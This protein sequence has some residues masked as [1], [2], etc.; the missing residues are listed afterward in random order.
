MAVISLL[1]ESTLRWPSTNPF[2]RAQALTMWIGS[3]PLARSWLPAQRLPVDGDD[4]GRK[5]LAQ[6]ARPVH[7]TFRELPR[8]EQ[9]EDAAEGIM[10]GDAIGQ[11]EKA[12]Q[13][14]AFGFSEALKLDKVLRPAEQRADC[15]H[16]D[17]MKAMGLGA[18]D[19]W[20]GD[21]REVKAKAFWGGFVGHPKLLSE[22][23]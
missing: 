6:A 21:E 5:A 18:L 22:V 15:N 8:V 4:L 20:V 12:R 14:F 2:S 3:R 9:G 16:Q 23:V 17:V 19:P 1:L 11:F 10:A 7:E 13:P